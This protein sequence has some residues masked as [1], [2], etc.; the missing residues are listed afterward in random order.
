MSY[1]MHL[2][3]LVHRMGGCGRYQW[4]TAI[5]VQ[6]AKAIAAMSM[7]AMTFNGQQPDFRCRGL[8]ET[9]ERDIS[10]DN[11]CKPENR[12]CDDGYDFENFEDSMDT[13]VNEVFL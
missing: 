2:E 10:F 4:L 7:I 1:G 9:P 6:S 3:D 8:V 12:T 13:I 11:E 5:I